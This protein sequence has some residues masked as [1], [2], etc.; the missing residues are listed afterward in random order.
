MKLKVI[1]KRLKFSE[2]STEFSEMA[3]WQSCRKFMDRCHRRLIPIPSRRCQSHGKAQLIQLFQE[4]IQAFHVHDQLLPFIF[5]YERN[6]SIY[7]SRNTQVA[8][9]RRLV[10]NI[11]DKNMPTSSRLEAEGHSLQENNHTYLTHRRVYCAP[12]DS[13]LDNKTNG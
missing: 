13:R 7:G 8:G 3:L 2:I 12:G 1:P 11:G 6:G 10:A 9:F 4:L 5:G